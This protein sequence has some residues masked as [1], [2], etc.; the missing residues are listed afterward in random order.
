LKLDT[1]SIEQELLGLESTSNKNKDTSVI[2]DSGKSAADRDVNT[3]R[4]DLIFNQIIDEVMVFRAKFLFSAS[5][6]KG[7][8]A[9][10]DWRHQSGG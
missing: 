8:F 6:F 9:R 10:H 1:L 4:I 7:C 3:N 5:G 2:S